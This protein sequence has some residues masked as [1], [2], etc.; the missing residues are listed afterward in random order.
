MRARGGALPS[1]AAQLG[2]GGGSG[3]RRVLI[4]SADAKIVSQSPDRHYMRVRFQVTTTREAYSD[5]CQIYLV[6]TGEQA[7]AAVV[8]C[9]VGDGR[10]GT[11][12]DNSRSRRRIRELRK[13]LGWDVRASGQGDA[14][15][16]FSVLESM[17]ADVPIAQKSSYTLSQDEMSELRR[18]AEERGTFYKD[19]KK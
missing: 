5:D 12:R 8:Q 11:E 9:R 3:V 14:F 6:P 1:C 7:S 4:G 2:G 16:S 19:S 17:F 13:Q 10:E 18:L 15:K